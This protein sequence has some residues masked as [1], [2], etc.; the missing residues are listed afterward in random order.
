MTQ[1]YQQHTDA[2]QNPGVL[3]GSAELEKFLQ[4][5]E[6]ISRTNDD[7]KLEVK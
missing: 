6:K 4:F 7:K 3:I 2:K 1:P 5:V